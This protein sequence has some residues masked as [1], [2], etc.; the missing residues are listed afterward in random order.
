MAQE[1]WTGWRGSAKTERT[2]LF[3]RDHLP[4]AVLVG[5]DMSELWTNTVDINEFYP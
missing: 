1:G 5:N 3:C 4:R 2:I